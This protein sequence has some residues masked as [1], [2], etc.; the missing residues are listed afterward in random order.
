MLKQTQAI[1]LQHL[2]SVQNSLLI[3]MHI[4][5]AQMI[6]VALLRDIYQ[7]SCK[8]QYANFDVPVTNM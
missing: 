5:T 1:L 4:A 3:V 6:G 2:P 8:L 7:S